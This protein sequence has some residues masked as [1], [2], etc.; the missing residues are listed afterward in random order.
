[1]NSAEQSKEVMSRRNRH[2]YIPPAAV[3]QSVQQSIPPT[4]A[5]PSISKRRITPFTNP[6][7]A[8]SVSSASP[9]PVPV[10]APTPTSTPV[11]SSGKSS[12]HVIDE[13]FF[14]ISRD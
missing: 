9:A 1:M 6:A 11:Q 14:L 7:A 8:M 4:P 12:K 2:S 5:T 13:L 3:T 10:S